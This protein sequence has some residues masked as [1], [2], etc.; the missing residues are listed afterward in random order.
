MALHPTFSIPH[1]PSC[2]FVKRYCSMPSSPECVLQAQLFKPSVFLAGSVVECTVSIRSKVQNPN[3]SKCC[4][5]TGLVGRV[6][7]LYKLDTKALLKQ[8]LDSP[9]CLELESNNSAEC[10]E[11]W[12]DAQSL[13]DSAIESNNL[14]YSAAM[15][16]KSKQPTNPSV[17]PVLLSV[18]LPATLLPSVRGKLVKI[19]YKLLIAVQVKI[20]KSS[21]PKGYLLQLPF[22]V[23][24]A[25]CMYYSLRLPE[26]NSADISFEESASGELQN[27]PFWISDSSEGES[28]NTERTAESRLSGLMRPS[29]ACSN[30]RQGDVPQSL[31]SRET[32]T[33]FDLF[34]YVPHSPP[35]NSL[36]FS[37]SLVATQPST[38]VISCSRGSVGRLCFLRTLF[39][40]ED[41]IRGYFDFEGSDVPCLSFTMSLQSE[42][43]YVPHPGEDS[44]FVSEKLPTPFIS[45]Q[46]NEKGE[47][48][49]TML[50]IDKGHGCFT[51]WSEV[52]YSCLGKRLLPFSFPIPSN[53][54]PQFHASVGRFSI[55][56]RW[57]LHLKFCLALE[58]P[59]HALSS[60]TLF[61]VPSS[62]AHSDPHEW[63]PPDDVKIERLTWDLPI[64][65][66]SSNPNVISYPNSV[67]SQPL[68]VC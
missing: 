24:P 41:S 14:L 25:P 5:I 12:F 40:L 27:N 48:Q 20:P 38:F 46:L 53:V 56:F 59:S 31:C 16:L 50:G 2:L 55:D 67:V 9:A 10:D 29:S 51:S 44:S 63:S 11:L 52:E 23:L 35:Y 26:R 28:S 42:E 18:R 36:G 32:E 47:P 8:K 37:R 30:S 7:G 68:Y 34:Q 21:S 39:R 3:D 33:V 64:Q 4:D 54:T 43:R 17:Y 58:S 60:T 57:H 66:V 61:S 1:T 45:Q 6:V 62:N 65:L 19:A 13:F 22:R 49:N 15:Q